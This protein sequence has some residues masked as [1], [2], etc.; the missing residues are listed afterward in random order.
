MRSS[1]KWSRGRGEDEDDA[2]WE[3][4]DF[5]PN[6]L[7]V[8]PRRTFTACTGIPTYIR[9]ANLISHIFVRTNQR[10]RV[11]RLMFTASE[12]HCYCLREENKVNIR[13]ASTLQQ[14]FIGGTWLVFDLLKPACNTRWM[15]CYGYSI[16]AKVFISKLQAGSIFMTGFFSGFLSFSNH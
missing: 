12:Q 15:D 14:S 2:A 8:P 5:V 6:V 3:V 7:F 11:V 13:K 10:K 9:F 16:F 4:A 1:R